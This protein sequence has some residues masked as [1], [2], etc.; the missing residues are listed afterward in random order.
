M[1]ELVAAEPC[2]FANRVDSLRERL[3]ASG[4][5]VYV[6][7]DPLLGE[8]FSDVARKSR[9]D[10]IFVLDLKRWGLSEN[11]YPYFVRIS[12]PLS[13]LLEESFT[14]AERQGDD[15]GAP[16]SICGWFSS[17]AAPK[18]I[19]S[20]LHSLM[21]DRLPDGRRWFFRFFDPRVIRHW[22]RVMGSG[23]RLS[24][25]GHWWYVADGEVRE[26]EGDPEM[27][28]IALSESQRGAFDRVG[29]MNQAFE[30]WREMD[31]GIDGSVC[32][33]LDEAIAKANAL[34]L[35]LSA[36]SDCV[37]FALHRCLIHP[38]IESH[39]QVARWIAGACE[40]G[41]AYVD[42]A[43]GASEALWAEIESGE[44]ENIS[45]EKRHG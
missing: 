10:E 11:Q 28:G 12:S 9:A 4:L 42:A 13:D 39:P 32:A 26:I 43:A 21:V 5:S 7:I 25:V 29:L 44:W 33:D 20:R 45:K 34:G 31:S 3:F 35:S 23:Q 40:G 24:G 18:D 36:Q 37:A 30:Q 1:A 19:Q 14:L 17:N 8:P 41:I 15:S 38:H 2:D 27:S 22:Q 16:R 6:F